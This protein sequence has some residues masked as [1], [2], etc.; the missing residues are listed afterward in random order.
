MLIG[1]WS[2]RKPSSIP[3]ERVLLLTGKRPLTRSTYDNALRY[4]GYSK[5]NPILRWGLPADGAGSKAK[6]DTC[7][8]INNQ[9]YIAL[10]PPH[11]IRATFYANPFI[12]SQYLQS[13]T[14]LAG[15]P[16]Y[17]AQE[18]SHFLSAN[19]LLASPFSATSSSATPL[20]PLFAHSSL[21]CPSS[22]FSCFSLRSD[23]ILPVSSNIAIVTI[24]WAHLSYSS[25]VISL[26]RVP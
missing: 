21:R 26:H 10:F 22:S 15:L 20:V 19:F 25:L 24:F 8:G 16:L 2:I 1:I 6:A 13:P 18:T 4:I 14:M 12:K 3:T 17:P 11:V 9:L 5:V 23:Y 7:C